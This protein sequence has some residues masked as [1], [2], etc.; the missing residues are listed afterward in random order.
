MT[1]YANRM[2]KDTN[3]SLDD[4]A[5]AKC[6]IM[7]TAT[8]ETMME[9]KNEM[10]KKTFISNFE[11]IAETKEALKRVAANARSQ[12]IYFEH[13]LSVLS[14]EDWSI[15][16]L[17]TGTGMQSMSEQI[18]KLDNSIGLILEYARDIE[19]LKKYGITQ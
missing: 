13:A 8:Q 4:T 2:D 3:C 1:T 19:K 14:N 9:G 6:R 11:T 17:T 5:N 7:E 18:A 16:V 15:D 12:A 10:K